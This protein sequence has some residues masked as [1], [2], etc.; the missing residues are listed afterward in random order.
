MTS[1]T[2]YAAGAMALLTVIT[3]VAAVALV[4][5][6][7]AAAPG[8]QGTIPTPTPYPVETIEY[9][10]S[11][12]GGVDET[13]TFSYAPMDGIE[14]GDTTVRSTYPRGMIFTLAPESPNGAIQDVILF[15]RFEHG[16]GGRV[17]AEWDEQAQQWVAQ[18]WPTGD[19]QPAWTHFNFYWRV[20][21]VSDVTVD[22]EPLTMD[23]WDPNREWFRLETDSYIIY[24]WNLSDN[25]PDYAAEY[26]AYA[27]EA[28]EPRRIEGFGRKISYK[29][30]GVIYGNRAAWDETYGSGISNPNAGGLTSDALGMSVQYVPGGDTD[31]NIQWLG[32]V[33]THELTHMYQFDVVGGA[34]G[35][36]WWTEGQAEWFAMNPGDYDARLMNLATVQDLPSFTTP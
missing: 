5:F 33:V 18:P 29:P 4:A 35:P 9:D 30:I 1:R 27:I 36:L 26:W 14:L 22:T 3:L 21:D 23:Y 12:V 13:L 34:N 10:L 31:I 7:A 32:S 11:V 19:G 17:V 28:T 25:N 2:R 20:R 24:W 16:S 6:P 8:A 15:I